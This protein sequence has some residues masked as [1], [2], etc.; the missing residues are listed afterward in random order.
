MN[1]FP[2]LFRIRKFHEDMNKVTLYV[3]QFPVLFRMPKFIKIWPRLKHMSTRFLCY[4]E[5]QVS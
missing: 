3:T 2:V 4:L 5:C 1:M